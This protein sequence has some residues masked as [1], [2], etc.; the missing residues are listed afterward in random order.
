MVSTWM[1]NLSDREGLPSLPLSLTHLVLFYAVL[2]DDDD[3]ETPVE[4]LEGSL[5]DVILKPSNDKVNLE[6]IPQ[7]LD[8]GEII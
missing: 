6:I 1:A 3:D 7:L 4:I 5:T 2:V 8:S